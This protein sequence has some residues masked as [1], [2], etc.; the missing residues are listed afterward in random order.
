MEERREGQREGRSYSI[1]NS[2]LL[3]QSAAPER[4]SA[5]SCLGFKTVS[6]VA[7]KPRE[8]RELGGSHHLGY[9]FHVTP[10]LSAATGFYPLLCL[11]PWSSDL[12]CSWSPEGNVCLLSR[13]RD[14]C[15]HYAG[16]KGRYLRSAPAPFSFFQPVFLVQPPAHLHPQK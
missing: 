8:G 4:D 2:F 7:W 16:R 10:L 14:G 5:V 12:L 13:W 1:C 6:Q 11:G 15:P 9:D 3:G